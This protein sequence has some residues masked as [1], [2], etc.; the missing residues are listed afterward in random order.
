MAK[1]AIDN[2]RATQIRCQQQTRKMVRS[3]TLVPPHSG[4]CQ[5][6]NLTKPR[7]VCHHYMGFD[8]PDMVWWICYSC[9]KKLGSTH[10]GRWKTP[11]EYIDYVKSKAVS[12]EDL[13]NAA[14]EYIKIGMLGKG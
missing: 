4:A 10:D 1:K 11:Q 8:R 5:I 9:N 14:I 13:I 3:G 12:R 7:L 6:C 2:R